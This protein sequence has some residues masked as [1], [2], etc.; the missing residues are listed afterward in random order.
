MNPIELVPVYVVEHNPCCP[1][2][3]TL[4]YK[5]HDILIKENA[6]ISTIYYVQFQDLD[7]IT[8]DDWDDAPSCCNSETPYRDRCDL[9]KQEIYLGQVPIEP[10]VISE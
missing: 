9:F 10:E 5:S 8:G 6:H 2:D 7:K 3:K 4:P 1:D